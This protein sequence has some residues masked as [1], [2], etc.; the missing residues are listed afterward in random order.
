MEK[1]CATCG[2]TSG[3]MCK[4]EYI[5]S[6]KCVSSKYCYYTP[7][8]NVTTKKE[9]TELDKIRM[10]LYKD[11]YIECLKAMSPSPEGGIAGK[12]GRNAVERFDEFFNKE[13]SNES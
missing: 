12:Y 1:Y 7:K 3:V 13:N 5:D 11:A 4:Y 10:S 8:N 2:N 6:L 9:I